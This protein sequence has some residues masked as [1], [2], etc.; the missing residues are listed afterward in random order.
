MAIQTG[1]SWEAYKLSSKDPLPFAKALLKCMEV[2][3][4]IDVAS[5]EQLTRVSA[6]EAIQP[7]LKMNEVLSRRTGPI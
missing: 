1:A 2:I 7:Y 5:K 3:F 4:T 6:M